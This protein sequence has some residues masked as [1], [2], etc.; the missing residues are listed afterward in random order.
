MGLGLRRR[1]SRTGTWLAGQRKTQLVRRD[2]LGDVAPEP[3]LQAPNRLLQL[4][5]VRLERL[6]T[7]SELLGLLLRRRELDQPRLELL[8]PPEQRVDHRREV[9]GAALHLSPGLKIAEHERRAVKALCLRRLR[10]LG[11]TGTCRRGQGAPWM[12]PA[13]ALD[14]YLMQRKLAI[15]G[16]NFS[17]EPG[18]QDSHGA[19]SAPRSREVFG[20][21]QRAPCSIPASRCAGRHRAALAPAAR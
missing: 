20:T 11:L 17:P 14:K 10:Q 4:L 3:D 6:D 21:M 8:H 18:M 16:E 1:W 9:G 12:P 7:A 5:I 15:L 2:L 19:P 13:L